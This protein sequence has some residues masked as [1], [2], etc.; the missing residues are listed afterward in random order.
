MISIST[1]PEKHKSDQR[2]LQHWEFA[3]LSHVAQA[4]ASVVADRSK[5]FTIPVTEDSEA[6]ARVV[7]E[8]SKAEARAGRPLLPDTGQCL[9]LSP[10]LTVASVT[11]LCPHKV[12]HRT[13]MNSSP[14]SRRSN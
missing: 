7:T 14:L 12:N 5:Y 13:N 2:P 4:V 6:E 10:D 9:G 3:I 8:D 11:F 1:F